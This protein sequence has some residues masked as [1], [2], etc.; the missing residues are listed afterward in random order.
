VEVVRGGSAL[1]AIKRMAD[2]DVLIQSKSSLS[3]V[4]GILNKEGVVYYPPKF[5]HPKLRGWKQI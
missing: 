2:A 5:W 3:Y 4:A 1:D